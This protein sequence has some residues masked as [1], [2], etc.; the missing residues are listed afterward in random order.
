MNKKILIASLILCLGL[1]SIVGFIG[2]EQSGPPILA[3]E[4]VLENTEGIVLG[5][6]EGPKT[7]ESGHSNR[8]RGDPCNPP[9]GE[10]NPCDPL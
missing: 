1:L 8:T 9:P 2:A 7:F 4:I 3:E 6:A 10:P 5:N